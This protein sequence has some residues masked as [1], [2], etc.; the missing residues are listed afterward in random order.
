MKN[1]IKYF[2]YFYR[3]LKYRLFI[4][5][6]ISLFVGLLD[7]IGLA[8]FIPLLKLV[9]NNA[10][11]ETAQEDP[12]SKFVIGYLDISPNLIQILALIL[13]F[14]SLKGIAKF[15]EG[16]V[17]VKYQQYFMRKVRLANIDLLNAYDFKSFVKADVGRI[18]NTFTGEVNRVNSALRYYFKAFQYGVLVLV[19]V[20]MAFVADPLFSLMVVTGGLLTNFLFSTLY[21]RTKFFS[22]KLTSQN[23]IFQDLLIQKVAFFKYLKTTGL[24]YIFGNKLKKNIHE[25][26]RLQMRIGIIDSLLAALR[27]PVIVSIIVVAIYLQIAFFDQDVG[28]VILSLLLLYRALTFFMGMQEQ[29]NF[30]LGVSGS[31]ENMEKFSHELEA[32]RESNGEELFNDFKKKL[33]FKNVSFKYD[34]KDVLKNINLEINKNETVAIVGE[35]GS[36]KSTLMSMISGLLKPTEGTYMIDGTSI[37]NLDVGSWKNHIGYVSQDVNVFNDTILNNVTFWDEKNPGNHQKFLNA[38]KKAAIY[39]FISKLSEKE[40]TLLGNNGINLSGGQKQRLSIARE[41]YKEVDILLM[42]EATSALD[43]ETEAII[44]QNIDKLKGELTIIVIAHRLAT[45]KKADR[46]IVLKKGEI[47]AT[48]TYKELLERSKDF[49]EMT[50]LQNL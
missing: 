22:R 46:I 10:T 40:E 23:H 44:Q 41:L 37:S 16:Y 27:E 17:R 33:E 38:I 25:L 19:Y 9:A 7:G 35:S 21:K 34:G 30:F 49:K 13:L 24:N 29:W 32:G 1:N 11:T 26:E 6:F 31:L 5:F 12:I 3:Y 50:E 43:G 20:V 48:G 47:K 8:L 4:T 45:I 15:F 42:D 18:Q 2:S 39:D 36:G 14:F 28:L